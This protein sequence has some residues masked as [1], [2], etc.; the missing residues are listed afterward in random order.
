MSLN[1]TKRLLTR[2]PAA[3]P[4]QQGANKHTRLQ[5]AI[6]TCEGATTG[7]PTHACTQT[8]VMWELCCSLQGDNEKSMWL[9]FIFCHQ[10]RSCTVHTTSTVSAFPVKLS[11]DVMTRL[12]WLTAVWL[13]LFVSFGLVQSLN[14]LWLWGL[15]RRN[16]EWRW[17][18]AV[19]GQ[20][21]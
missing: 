12:N 3:S 1:K 18:A 11:V 10:H 19:S 6:L 21:D 2:R 4:R 9:K 8:H 14:S 7:G 16:D 15:M 17:H 20:E 13:F 5:P